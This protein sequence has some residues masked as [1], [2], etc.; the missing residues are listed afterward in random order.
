MPVGLSTMKKMMKNK[1]YVILCLLTLGLFVLITVQEQT[2]FIE[3]KPLNGVLY[4]PEKKPIA[5]AY[6]IDGSYQ[7]SL[8]TYLRYN[9]G[10]RELF[11]KSYNQYIW[12]FYHKTLNYTI[13]IGKDNWLYGLDEV[14][15]Y[16]QSSVYSYTQSC[17]EMQHKCDL[18]AQR[19]YKVQHILDEYG[20]FIFLS[21]LPTKTF[22]YPEYMPENPGLTMPPF[23]AYQYYPKLFDS[24]GVNYINVMEIFQDW[25]D[26]VDFPL[27]PKTGK[28]WSYIAS[29]YAFDTIERYIEHEGHMNL[30]NYKM[31]GKYRGETEYPDN[32]LESLM[33]LWRPI[34]PNQNYYATPVLDDD[35]TAFKPTIIVVGDSYFWNLTRSVPLGFVF[36]NYYYW[37]YNSSVYYNPKY[38]HTSDADMLYE[39]LNAKVIDLSYSPEQLYVFSND[40]LSKALLY[41]T[42]DDAEIDS[43]V[44]T[45]AAT[46]EKETEDERMEEARK[47]LFSEPE[48]YFPDLATDSVPVTRNSRIPEILA[49]RPF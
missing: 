44:A 23:H 13:C 8:E 12:D 15:N 16:Y 45:I 6:M 33:N 29:G 2:H 17:A 18:E 40:F 47:T 39:I 24:L 31:G 19:L 43:T 11:I 41:L 21:M 25:K 22:L 5:I 42:H 26:K 28:H 36:S 27:Y 7:Q 4:E 37:Y 10:F 32:D 9:F 34:R 48:R 20:N 46:V 49:A 38:D 1:I 14:V 35:S 30:R 3:V